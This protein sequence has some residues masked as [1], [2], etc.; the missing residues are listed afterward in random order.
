VLSDAEI[1]PAGISLYDA[2]LLSIR[3]FP[4]AHLNRQLHIP[5]KSNES[6]EKNR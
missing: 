5:N 3:F 1:H 2:A 6:D 4:L